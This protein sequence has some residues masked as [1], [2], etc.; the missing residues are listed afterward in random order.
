MAAGRYHAQTLADA[1]WTHDD[2]RK[3]A[4]SRPEWRNGVSKDDDSLNLGLTLL[5]YATG[6]NL[7]LI[8]EI[9]GVARIG[10]STS[11]VSATDQN[12]R[13]Y[14]RSGT[15]GDINSSNDI[16]IPDG[17]QIFTTAP[18]ARCTWPIP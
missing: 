18:A 5:Y 14:V 13:F 6:G 10:A 16:Q 8:G 7:D 12:F 2:W 9:F 4:A 1:G 11:A 3:Y 17:V 15:F